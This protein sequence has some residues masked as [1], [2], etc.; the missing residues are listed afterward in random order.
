MNLLAISG[1]ATSGKNT[2][3]DLLKEIFKDK[4]ELEGFQLA[5]EL[6]VDCAP[7]IK[8]KFNISAFT[9]DIKEKTLIRPIF[10]EVAE[11]RRTLSKGKFYTSLLEPKIQESIGRGALPCVNDLRFDEYPEDEVYWVKKLGGIIIHVTR[12]EK[13]GSMVPPANEKE[14]R[15]LAKLIINAD[16]CL[17]W[18]TSDNK[19]YLFDIVKK[20]LS[21]VLE[22]INL[23]YGIS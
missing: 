20:Q 21:P 8:E 15:N 7:F 23:K 17:N 5:D 2:C 16:F 6:K 14:K 19:E 4:V 3:F 11:I 12:Y 1:N 18:P 9:R 13:D 10:V 22:M